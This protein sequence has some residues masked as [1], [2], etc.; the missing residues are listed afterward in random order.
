MDELY[1]W[2]MY[3]WNIK[4]HFIEKF[5]LD[6]SQFPFLLKSIQSEITDNSIRYRI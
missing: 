3:Q 5:V 1:I 6:I 4:W 2:I